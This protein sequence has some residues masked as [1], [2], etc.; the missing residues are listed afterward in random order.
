M[1]TMSKKQIEVVENLPKRSR[2]E[3][4]NNEVA[5]AVEISVVNK[6]QEI[7]TEKLRETL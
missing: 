5:A 2:Y 6:K 4:G 1:R 7:F 3:V